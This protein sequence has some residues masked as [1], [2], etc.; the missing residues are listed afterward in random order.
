[1]NLFYEDFTAGKGVK[2]EKILSGE[3]SSEAGF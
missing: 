1:M 2:N 3:D